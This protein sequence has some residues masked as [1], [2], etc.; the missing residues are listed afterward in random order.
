LLRLS[1]AD[2]SESQEIFLEYT[3]GIYT[4]QADLSEYEDS[5]EICYEFKAYNEGGEVSEER[6]TLTIDGAPPNITL[7]SP[8]DNVVIGLSQEFSFFAAD[9]LAQT[10]T[11]SIYSDDKEYVIDIEAPNMEIVSIP[12]ADLEEGEH[13]W[14]VRCTDP[15]GWNRVSAARVYNLDKTPPAIDMKTPENN[16]IIADSTPLE[17]EV[18]DNYGIVHVFLVRDGNTTEV[19][20]EFIVDVSNWPNGPSEFAVIAEDPVGNQAELTYRINIDRNPPKV[21]LLGPPYGDTSDVHVNFTYVV[22]DDNDDEIECAVYIDNLEL[23]I[24]IAQGEA[25]TTRSELLA[26]GDYTWRVQCVDDAGNSGKSEDRYLSVAD[27]TGPD[28]VDNSADKV[29]RGDP[30]QISLVVTDISGVTGVTAVLRDPYGDT[31]TIALEIEDGTYTASV[32]TTES[33]AVGTYTLEVYGVDTLNH[34]NTEN[35]EIEVTYNYIVALELD[36]N[37]I[38]PGGSVTLTGAVVYDNGSA[39][40]ESSISL[41]LLEAE[42]EVTLDQ[43]GFTYELTAPV[44]EGN[45]DITASIVSEENSEEYSKTVQFNVQAPQVQSS[46]S[47]GS[48]GS[49]G[50]ITTDALFTVEDGCESDVRCTAWTMCADTMQEKTCVDLNHCAGSTKRIET[51]SCDSETDE[52]EKDNDIRTT[53]IA[54]KPAARSLLPDPEEYTVDAT[55]EDEKY[56]P[57]IGKAAGFMSELK[58]DLTSVL[59]VLAMMGLI[60]GVLSKYGWSNGDNR[61]RPAAVDLLGKGDK[62]DLESYL[63]DRAIRRGKF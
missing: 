26:T 6:G 24:H 45:Y 44:E 34:F 40:P 4:N 22:L 7:V 14:H 13:A 23:Q 30:I 37:T 41:T 60:I 12:S 16:S 3:E 32:M 5:A 11:C 28:I 57:G 15:A 33:S 42:T 36:S 51:R 54:A 21:D 47:G 38:M 43:G 58:F 52:E 46:S 8:D 9:N 53:A 29:F 49:R 27:L 25:E 35:F 48:G 59:I 31:Q 63:D 39:V 56:T 19:E 20:S 1:D 10:M 61:S 18:T 62:L 2:E 55:D 17:F 50:R